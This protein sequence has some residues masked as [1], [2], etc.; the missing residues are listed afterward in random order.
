MPCVLRVS[1]CPP[2]LRSCPAARLLGCRRIMPRS[3]VEQL[4]DIRRSASIRSDCT[5]ILNEILLDVEVADA[6]NSQVAHEASLKR[7]DEDLERLRNACLEF[8]A[9][10]AEKARRRREELGVPF[11]K[12]LVRL[13]A[14]FDR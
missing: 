3:L 12:E 14:T 1:S 9:I 8:K 6:I 7:K 11:V 13:A 2:L 4:E 5:T 10:E